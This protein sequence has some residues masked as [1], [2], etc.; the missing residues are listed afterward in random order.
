M[1]QHP[2]HV[3]AA[4][5]KAGFR[6]NEGLNANPP[7]PHC[8]KCGSINTQFLKGTGIWQCNSTKGNRLPMGAYKLRCGHQFPSPAPF[9]HHFSMQRVP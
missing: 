1:Q 9:P 7:R 3:P 2:E 5:V 6:L 8:P 4:F